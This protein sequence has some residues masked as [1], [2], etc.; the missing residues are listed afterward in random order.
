MSVCVCVFS[1]GRSSEC[2]WTLTRCAV[3]LNYLEYKIVV[4]EQ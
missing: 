4:V 3:Q 1:Y 2:Y